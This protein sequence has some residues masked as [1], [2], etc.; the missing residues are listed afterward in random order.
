MAKTAMIRARTTPE[1]KADAERVFEKLG[2]N[3]SE[4]INLFLAQVRIYKGIPFDVRIPNKTTLETFKKT[5]EGKELVKCK[6]ADDMFRKLGI[7]MYQPIHTKQ[8]KKDIN[9]IDKSGNRDIEKLKEVIGILIDGKKL[10]PSY[11]DH[12]LKGDFK[13][14]RECHIKPDWL[15]VYKIVKDEKI[16]IFERTGSHSDIFG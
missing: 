6:D 15:L 12:K 5:D 2:I 10:D 1:L 7:W 13:D 8:F 9:R 16:I 4:A 11:R 3:T 14:R